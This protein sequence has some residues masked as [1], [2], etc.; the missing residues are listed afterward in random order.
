MFIY[1]YPRY[2]GLLYLYTQSLI[3]YLAKINVKT[4]L[5]INLTFEV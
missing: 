3:V 2:H 5:K 1:A 4:V